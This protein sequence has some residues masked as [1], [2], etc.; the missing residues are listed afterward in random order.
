MSAIQS[1]ASR[2]PYSVHPSTDFIPALDGFRA[3]SIALVVVSH[4]GMESWVPGIFGVNIF[5][6]VSGLLITRQILSELGRSNTIA[7][8]K[9]YVRRLLRLYPALLTAVLLGG[10]LYLLFGGRLHLGDVLAAVLYWSNYWELNG[11]YISTLPSAIH[12]Y[13]IFWSLAVEE[14]YYLFFPL[15]ALLFGRRRLK[16]AVLL[17]LGIVLVTAWREYLALNCQFRNSGCMGG[18]WFRDWRILHATDTRI[19]SILYGALLTVLLGSSV[20]DRLLRVLRSS[21]TFLFGLGLIVGSL[22]IRDPMFRQTFRFTI[23][24]I[25]LFFCVGSTLF[26]PQFELSLIH[27]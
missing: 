7:L 8:G 23:Q 15:I 2:L 12:P 14:H 25:G 10:I 26:A 11:G 3:L 20:S 6:F 22:L 18:Y 13:S 17:L 21:W 9:F 1:A 5:F 27:I 4:L 19:D 16:F 24:G